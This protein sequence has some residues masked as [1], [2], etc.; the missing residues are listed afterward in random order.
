MTSRMEVENRMDDPY[1][2]HG[3]NCRTDYLLS[4]SDEYDV[5]SYVVFALADVLGP[6]EDF[7]G[8]VTSLEDAG[9]YF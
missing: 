4:L 8:L 5:P 2:A 3:Y 6:N 1:L 9:G 7:D